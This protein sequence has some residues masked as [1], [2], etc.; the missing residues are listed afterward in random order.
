VRRKV[1]EEVRKNDLSFNAGVRA[2]MFT[3]PG[4]GDVDF[5]AIRRVYPDF[6]VSRLGGGRS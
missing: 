1:L 2:G 3:V 5:T 6:R 4:D